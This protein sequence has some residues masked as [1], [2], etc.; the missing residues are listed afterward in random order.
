MRESSWPGYGWDLL[1][2]LPEGAA[3]VDAGSGRVLDVNEALCS[4][5]RRSRGELVSSSLAELLHWDPEKAA[6]VLAGL[7]APGDDAGRVF[8]LDLPEG[9]PGPSRIEV[10]LRAAGVDEKPRPVVAL[11]RDASARRRREQALR[12]QEERCAIAAQAA[13]LGLWDWSLADDRVYFSPELE[14]ML[15]HRPGELGEVAADWFQRVHPD[16]LEKLQAEIT[17]H[18]NG[19]STLFYAEHRVCNSRGAYRWV[20]ARGLAVREAD[21]EARRIVGSVLDVT[22]RKLDE[23]RLL[24]DAFYDRLTGLPNRALFMDRLEQAR[25]RGMRDGNH[26]YAVLVLDLDRFKL[27]NDSFSHAFGDD[28]LVAVGQRLRASLRPGDTLARLGGDEFAILLDGL[29][30]LTHATRFAER[31]HDLLSRPLAVRD[32]KIFSLASIGIACSDSGYRSP[33]DVLRDADSAMYRAKASSATPHV[34]FDSAMHARA[35]ERLTLENDLRHGVERE[36][37]R[38][39]YQPIV[40]L[41]SG[42]LIAFES[43]LRWT[44]PTRGMLLPG[45]FL[46]TAEETGLIGELGWWVLRRAC[47]DLKGWMEQVPAAGSLALTVNLAAQQLANPRLATMVREVLEEVG[48]S[49]K[50]LRLEITENMIIRTPELVAHMLDELRGIGAHVCLDDFG[51]GYASLSYLHRFPIDT[52]KID[53]SFIHQI[54]REPEMLEIVRSV[55]S[56]GRNIGMT[57]LGEGIESAAQVEALQALGCE[58]GQGFHLGYPQDADQT[59]ALIAGWQSDDA[60]HVRP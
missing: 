48:L 45:A 54:D 40:D 36:E 27:V 30:S 12:T 39:H 50:R 43:L 21:G 13:G 57:V 53:Q 34:L 9:G 23:A 41:R 55:V 24:H 10:S 32:Q 17:A 5:L 25:A 58:Y 8:D 6:E 1:E 19:K 52:I 14:Q 59:R 4:L 3:L 51:T 26:R 49:P 18:Q 37:F 44:H 11:V 7:N 22:H 56:L 38:V 31:V 35:M 46:D 47:Q 33:D 20:L 28:L 2:A 15:G 42:Q 29:E 60:L 16:D